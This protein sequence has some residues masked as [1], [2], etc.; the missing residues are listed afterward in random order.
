M[1]GHR[2][3]FPGPQGIVA[4]R[5]DGRL[6]VLPARAAAGSRGRRGRPRVLPELP[7]RP[8][9]VA[10]DGRWIELEC[11]RDGELLQVRIP[12]RSD[13]FDV[14][15][16]G[17]ALEPGPGPIRPGPFRA[18]E[19]GDGL[20]LHLGGRIPLLASPSPAG[21]WTVT[22]GTREFQLSVPPHGRVVSPAQVEGE[23]GLAVLLERELW[24][25]GAAGGRR[26]ASLGNE[27]EEASP[28]AGAPWLALLEGEVVSLRG[29]GSRWGQRL[30]RWD[31]P[32]C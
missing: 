26:R 5:G 20:P 32:G 14:R 8:L 18:E 15:G 23:A 6:V 9:S 13:G 3:V 4:R 7:G 31:L 11:W 19:V 12:P 25:Q 29:L 2:L 1:S 16:L 27:P 21:G 28:C 22:S 24:F 17:A 10:F 30:G